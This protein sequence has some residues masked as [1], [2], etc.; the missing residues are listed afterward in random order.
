MF[1]LA[2][3]FY[4]AGWLFVCY[5][6]SLFLANTIKKRTMHRDGLQT[7]HAFAIKYQNCVSNFHFSTVLADVAH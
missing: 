6:V 4:L 1:G 7:K 3:L 5:F 2:F